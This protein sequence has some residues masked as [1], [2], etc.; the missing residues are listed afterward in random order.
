[1]TIGPSETAELIFKIDAEQ[2]LV[3]IRLT[4]EG[5]K[6]QTEVRKHASATA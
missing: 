1:M 5:V 2:I 6:S 4:T 3:G